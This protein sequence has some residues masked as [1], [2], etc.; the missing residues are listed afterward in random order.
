MRNAVP[1][2]TGNAFVSLAINFAGLKRLL[3]IGESPFSFGVAV[4]FVFMGCLPFVV[5]FAS[6][7]PRS[8]LTRREAGQVELLGRRLTDLAQ[9]RLWQMATDSVK[10]IFLGNFT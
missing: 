1:A 7:S 8:R 3:F 10:N 4:F 9:V 5:F 6:R 2:R